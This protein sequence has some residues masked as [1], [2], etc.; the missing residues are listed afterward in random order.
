MDLAENSSAIDPQ[1]LLM[2]E[3][4]GNLMREQVEPDRL[5]DAEHLAVGAI[6]EEFQGRR[7]SR[8]SV[9]SRKSR[10]NSPYLRQMERDVSSLPGT[11]VPVALTGERATAEEIF[12]PD[13]TS[14]K[15]RMASE[16][17]RTKPLAYICKFCSGLF[18]TKSKRDRTCCQLF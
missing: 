3:G 18:T 6:D 5:P 8:H 16:R 9:S 10:A 4:E 7:L 11:S 14:P 15:M 2:P 12:K 1:V 17:R 13:V